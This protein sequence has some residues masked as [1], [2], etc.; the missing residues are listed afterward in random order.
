MAELW[1]G[2]E[3]NSSQGGGGGGGLTAAR[4]VGERDILGTFR[5]YIKLK[6]ICVCR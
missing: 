3:R 2:G 5:F 1:S 6:N 4:G